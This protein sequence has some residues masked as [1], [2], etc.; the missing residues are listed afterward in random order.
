MTW[1]ELL[2]IASSMVQ[3]LTFLH[4][5]LPATKLDVHKPSVAHRDF[6]SRNVL[7]RSDMTACVADFGLALVFEPTKNV[8]Y[9]HGQ[10]RGICIYNSVCVYRHI[11]INFFV[12]VP[13]NAT[14]I[15]VMTCIHWRKAMVGTEFLYS[16]YRA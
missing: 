12:S 6:K 3:G 4:A 9:T 10:V 16:I 5:D 7:I 15:A 2:Q 14:K 8:G 13:L 1:P 11:H